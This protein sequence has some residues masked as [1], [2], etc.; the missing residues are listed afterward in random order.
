MKFNIP[1]LALCVVCGGL[2]YLISKVT[3]S[4]E[5][6]KLVRSIVALIV[7]SIAFA[8][9]VSGA[10]L[11]RTKGTTVNPFN[12]EQ[13]TYLVTS[14][15]YAIT[16]NPMYLGFSLCLISLSVY[17]GNIVSLLL[18]VAFTAYMNCVQIPSEERALS[19]LFGKQFDQYKS[20]VR[21]WL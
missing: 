1:P 15:I 3:W 8:F 11:F 7:L 13:A 20:K 16:R 19:K 9:V 5:G 14:G 18:V 10:S 4:F 17:L 21:R 12:P 2:M 6:L